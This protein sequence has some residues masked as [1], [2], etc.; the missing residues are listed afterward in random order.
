MKK[1]QMVVLTNPVA[2]R[3]AEFDAWYD[4]V[5][6]GQ[7]CDIEGFTGARRLPLQR[8]MSDGPKYVSLAIYDIETDDLDA[9]LHEM[10]RRSGS[11]QLVVSEALDTANLYAGIYE[12]KSN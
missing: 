6:L 4:E 10:E 3:E 7:V 8:M 2:D 12:V 1:Y 5:H 9:A 11:E